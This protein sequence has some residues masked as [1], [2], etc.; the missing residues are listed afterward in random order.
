MG[1]VGL[2]CLVWLLWV[3]CICYSVYRNDIGDLV[4]YS[5][6]TE[7]TWAVLCLFGYRKL[8]L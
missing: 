3:L 8:A 4:N 7:C 5:Y 6:K 1:L 2:D